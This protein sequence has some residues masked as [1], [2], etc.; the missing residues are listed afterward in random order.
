MAALAIRWTTCHLR[1]DMHPSARF[2]DGAMRLSRHH[3]HKHPRDDVEANLISVCGD[4]TTGC[5]GLIE[6]H[7]ERALWAL[8][9]AVA[10]R[11]DTWEYLVAKLGG[12][13][14]ASDWLRRLGGPPAG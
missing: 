2:L 7:N 10:S 4:G 11:V 9:R 6:A 8:Q 14:A 3:I 5:H 1:D 13:D 12:P